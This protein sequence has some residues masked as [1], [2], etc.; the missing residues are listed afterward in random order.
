MTTLCNAAQ[1]RP[2]PR[3]RPMTIRSGHATEQS[4]VDTRVVACDRRWSDAVLEPRLGSKQRGE[5][6]RQGATDKRNPPEKVAPAERAQ[7]GGPGQR[8]GD[9]SHRNQ[10]EAGGFYFALQ[11]VDGPAP[12]ICRMRVVQPR[13]MR[14]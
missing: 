5:Q 3:K 11:S 7:H 6:R 2:T 4:D 8:P 10:G 14:R 12:K 9:R 1:A 13:P